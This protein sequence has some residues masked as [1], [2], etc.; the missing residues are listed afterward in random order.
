MEI[1]KTWLGYLAVTTRVEIDVQGA[2]TGQGM[3][4]KDRAFCPAFWVCR[5]ADARGVDPQ[6]SPILRSDEQRI[7]HLDLA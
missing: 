3:E 6:Q 7:P 5:P 2:R 4:G 1:F